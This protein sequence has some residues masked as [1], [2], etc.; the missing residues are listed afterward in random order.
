MKKNRDSHSR[1]MCISGV[2]LITIQQLY[3][4]QMVRLPLDNAEKGKVETVGAEHLATVHGRLE[5]V[6]GAVGKALLL[7]GESL[8][9]LPAG[10]DYSIESGPF[11]VAAWVNTYDLSGA[12]QM[13]A[14]KNDYAANKREWGL[15]IDRDNRFAFYLRQGGVENVEKQDSSGAWSLVS[16]GGGCR[17]RQNY[18]LYQRQSG[19]ANGVFREC[20]ADRRAFD[21]RRG[22]QWRNADAAVSRSSG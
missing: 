18:A 16:S 17:R 8:I 14:A 15:M 9:T 5:Q 21:D 10:S 11:T 19:R 1:I 7:D 2:I 22:A 12:Q 4:V 6:P 13:I 3:A 20:R